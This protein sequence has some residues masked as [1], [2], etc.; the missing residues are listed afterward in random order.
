MRVDGVAHPTV[1]PLAL[2]RE[3]VKL[4]TP[5]NGIVLEPFA[6]SGTTVEACLLEGVVVIAI[7]REVS[8]LSLIC[9]RISRYLDHVEAERVERDG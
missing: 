8:Y 1:K 7:E 9:Q 5:P 4:V 3:L 6:G 2:M